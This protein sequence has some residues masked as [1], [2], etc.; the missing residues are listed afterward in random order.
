MWPDWE[1]WSSWDL[2]WSSVAPQASMRLGA[3]CRLW[4]DSLCCDSFSPVPLSSSSPLC[5]AEPPMGWLPAVGMSPQE[6]PWHGAHPRKKTG[7]CSP[8]GRASA[9]SVALELMIG[10]PSGTGGAIVCLWLGLV[11]WCP[12]W[13]LL[14]RF[15]SAF[16]VACA[17]TCGVHAVE[18]SRLGG[19]S[20]GFICPLGW[21]RVG[22]PR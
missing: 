21:A 10:M 1:F 16:P 17:G 6:R 14:P 12:E 8:I 4:G 9:W 18:S 5:L 13:P 11:A 20:W 19:S 2:L 15:I 3:K 7:P 22:I